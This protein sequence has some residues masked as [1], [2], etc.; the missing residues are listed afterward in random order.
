[1]RLEDLTL[2]VVSNTDCFTIMDLRE[3][4]A[5]FPADKCDLRGLR[6]VH[7][8]QQMCLD[9]RHLLHLAQLGCGAHLEELSLK[10]VPVPCC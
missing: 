10:S 2:E 1:M 4:C 5:L 7:F 8:S 6:R 9:D 3:F